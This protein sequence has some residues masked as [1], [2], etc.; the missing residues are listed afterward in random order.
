MRLKFD[1]SLEYQQD[2]IHAV[3]NAFAGQ[4]IM[5]SDFEISTHGGCGTK[6]SGFSELGIGNII[7]LDDKEILTNVQNVQEKNDI[8][9]TTTLQGR[10]FS[11]EMETGTGKTY[12]Y[13]RS[14]FEL[15]KRYGL[16]KFII[17]VPSV[18]IREGVLKSIEIMEE[19]FCALYNN[20][21]FNYFVY[22]SKK[23]VRVRQFASSNQIQIMVINI[24]SFQ[25]DVADQD[26]TEMT[27]DDLKKLNVINRENDKMSGLKPIEFIQ[28]TKPMVIIDEPQS[29][30]NTPKAKRAIANLKP[31]ATL[32]YSATHRN[33]YN[34]LYKIDPVRA[35]DLRLVKRIEV[36]SIRS[37]DSFN[38]A[39]VKLLKTD[40]K[41]GIKAQVEIHKEKNG[42]VQAAKVMVKQSDDLY[43]KSGKRENY[44][45][46]YIVQNIDCTPDA[47]YIEFNNGRSINLGHEIGGLGDDIMQ[48]QVRIT[49][50]QHL[51]KEQLLKGKGKDIK[52][53]SLFFIDKV[54]NYRIYNDDGSTGLGKIGQ[55]FEEAYRELVAKPGYKKFATDDISKIHNGY[56]SQDNSGRVKNT[57]GKTAADEDTYNL[58]MRDKER[59]LDPNEPLRFIFSHSA[60]RE[61]WD[62]PNVFQICTLNES[63]S[64]EKKRQEIGRGLRLPVNAHG[65]RVH[66]ENVNCLTIIANESYKDFARSLQTEFEEDCGIKFGQID[67][68][69][70]AKIMR[71]KDG[72]AEEAIG[73]EESARVWEEVKNAGYIN[74][75]GEILSTF[76]PQNPELK[77]AEKYNDINANIIDV[78]QRF[79]FKNR[80]ANACSRHTLKLKEENYLN[81]NFKALWDKI[82]HRTRYCMSFETTKLIE[83]AVKRIKE[84]ER[85]KPP[86]ITMTR[87]DV[88][89]TAAG[90]SADRRM[91][92]S[93]HET[94]G[95]KTLP[96]L[97]AYLQKETEL[98]RHTLVEI[99]KRS[100][101]LDEFQVNPQQFM[102]L[103]ARGISRALHG[104]MKDNVQYKKIADS[105]W[106]MDRIEQEA[107]EGIVRYLNNLYEVQ[108]REKC[109]FDMVEY[110]SEV[111]RQFA[112]DLDNNENVLFYMKLPSW[113]QI[114]TPIG[115]YNPD[116]AFVTK[117]DK[118]LY[119]V[120][121]TKSTLDDQK[122]RVEENQKIKYGERHFEAIGVDYGVVTK[123][124]EVNF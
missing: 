15:A 43:V 63:R 22:D 79:I 115:P 37:D 101:R 121:E 29:V 4:P 36:A 108:N 93:S 31:V 62:N 34:L 97:L 14:I 70:F 2:A 57:N 40:N 3:V 25:K 74:D 23:L 24:Q 21:S 84:L 117:R 65:D 66:D 82:K 85:I 68:I 39:Y 69:A 116:W 72:G 19:H 8:E 9:K 103:T 92:E 107:E 53:L 35:Y 13:L 54:A 33:L 94:G 59:L 12:V 18:A 27:D 76:D 61:G 120:R 89:L 122:R 32:R 48:A 46:G 30:D 60:L 95:V 17:V 123:L 100:G 106:E 81:E 113:F 78:M 51:K 28:A 102:T 1:P 11:I 6:L 105:Y 64:V 91:E 49:V 111:E 110:D 45:D 44:R 83:C 55:W 124:K 90:V 88:D 80:V 96:D 109:L 42:N 5:Q 38:D 87:V 52:V 75:T 77:I 58:I 16:K 98:T 99:L 47:E 10:N 112:K 7:T 118:K 119:F 56:F 26:T 20:V 86:Y 67:K 41:N 71:S 73:Q 50:E 104:M 114:D